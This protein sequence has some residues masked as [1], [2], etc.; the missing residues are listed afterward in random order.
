[1]NK[2]LSSCALAAIFFAGGCGNSPY[3]NGKTYGKSVISSLESG[4]P[5]AIQKAME[6]A[7]T[8]TEGM[9]PANTIEFMQGYNEV[10]GPYI[11]SKISKMR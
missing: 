7:K 9:S 2:F 1:M 8:K 11:Q 10:T 3:E 4:S 5:S 6:I